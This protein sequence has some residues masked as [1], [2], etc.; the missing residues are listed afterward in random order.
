MLPSF[1]CFII[2]IELVSRRSLVSRQRYATIFTSYI[3]LMSPTIRQPHKKK[4][5][6]FRSM[7]NSSIICLI[8]DDFSLR[9]ILQWFSFS[10]LFSFQRE[11][12]VLFV[13]CAVKGANKPQKYVRMHYTVAHEKKKNKF[14]FYV[15]GK[16]LRKM[17]LTCPFIILRC[18]VSSNGTKNVFFFCSPGF[19]ISIKMLC[20]SLFI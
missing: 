9:N 18:R 17:F 15:Y 6:F 8:L 11:F 5:N 10:N 20:S 14:M 4:Y 13:V 16:F 7:T 3:I 1:L 19:F 12:I 2:F